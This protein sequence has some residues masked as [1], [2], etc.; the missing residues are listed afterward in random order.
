[1]SCSTQSFSSFFNI[2]FARSY[3]NLYLIVS[4]FP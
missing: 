4:Y 1:M 2:I 3:I